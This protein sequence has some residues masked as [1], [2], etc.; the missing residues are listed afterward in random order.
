ML[1]YRH[2]PRRLAKRSA[3]DRVESVGRAHGDEV[4]PWAVRLAEQDVDA[5]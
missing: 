3:G 2:S 1:T 4:S 5:R